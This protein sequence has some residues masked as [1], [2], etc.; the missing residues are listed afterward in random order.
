MKFTSNTVGGTV[1]I[2]KRFNGAQYSK[3]ITVHASAF[4]ADGVCLAGTPL[5]A[6]G[7]IFSVTGGT[8]G[9]W[10]VAISTAFASDE[11]IVINGVTYTKGASQSADNKVFAG[12]S[13]TEQ[14]TSL[15]A[16]VSDENFT[17]T[18]SSGTIT[19]TQKNADTAGSAPTVTKTG[20]TG[21]IGEVTAGTSPVD[22]TPNAIGILWND[23][24]D[25]NPNGAL[26]FA[27]AVI[28]ESVA[29]SHC[30]RN[31]SDALKAKLSHLIFD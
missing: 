8:K 2:V 6:D 22:G 7:K 4:N 12:S 25:E 10:S 11:T 24:Y 21:A 28:N 19:F 26:L 16:I 13:A 29:E 20:T 5:D 18:A 1:E 9:T 31:Y 3:P 14:A 30:G 27:D 17:L 23:V 15:V